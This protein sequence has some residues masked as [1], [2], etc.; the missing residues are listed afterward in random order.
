MKF[1]IKQLEEAKAIH[2]GDLDY[3]KK[4]DVRRI[5]GGR[6][7]GHF[8]TG[9]YFVGAEGP[10]GIGGSKYRDYN[11]RRPIYEIELDDYNLFK[12]KDNDTAY[13]IHDNLRTINN[14]YTDNIDKYLFKEF[15]KDKMIDDIYYIYEQADELLDEYKEKVN[16][17][18]DEEDKKF[19]EFYDKVAKEFIAQNDLE[20]Y[21]PG[22]DLDYYLSKH[23]PSQIEYELKKAIEEL[24]YR[25]D[26]IEYAINDLCKELDV[27]KNRL[28]DIIRKSYQNKEDEE[29]ISTHIFKDLGYEGVD[30]THLNKDAQ[31]LSGLDNF[32]YGTVIYDLKPGTFKRIQEP[33]EISNESMNE[34]IKNGKHIIY[35]VGQ[36]NDFENG[37]FFADSLDY[38]NYSDTG[39]SKTDAV[40]Y[41]V[42]FTGAKV[43]N[44]ID[45]WDLVVN[46]WSDIRQEE[47]FFKEK[48]F[49]YYEYLDEVDYDDPNQY[50]E[51]YTDTDYLSVWAK[52]K[53]YDACILK[54]IPSYGGR[55]PDFTEYCI[56][57]KDLIKPMQEMSEEKRT[58][59]MKFRL[60]E[61][62]KD[63]SVLNE[64]YPNKGES[65]KDFI[66]RFMSVTKDEYPNVKQRYAV[67]KS[68]WK[69][70]DKR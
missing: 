67:A 6:G 54:D 7:T 30:V 38:Y 39:Y 2:W 1:E 26:S 17:S 61:D 49:P 51:V 33:R 58:N 23:T 20:R 64:I 43:F 45:D 35:R 37:L 24:E 47:E 29:T 15:D 18:E 4:A 8:G 55:G 34:E 3:G 22:T 31:G 28:L 56:F 70:R 41:E 36:T 69:R 27:D 52:E 65:E 57:N 21:M 13:K 25:K 42:D 53:G 60:I 12:P 40:A 44:P 50:H 59:T 19:K 11:P 48:D 5:M 32:T 62:R 63:K 10:Y 9:F 16:L 68:Y 46:T 14:K 66:S